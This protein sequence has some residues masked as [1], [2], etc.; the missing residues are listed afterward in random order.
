MD[1]KRQIA[2]LLT[3]YMTE[4]EA[5][6]ALTPPKDVAMGDICLPC[7][8]LAKTMRKSPILIAEEL[9][10]AIER[11]AFV[12]EITAVAGYL[13]FR[14]APSA[15]AHDI[16]DAVLTAGAAYGRTD[17]GGGRNVC[18]D[19]S[20][21][22]IAKPF[23][24]GHLSTTVLGAALARL[25]DEIGYHSVGINHLGDWGT[26][27]GKLIVAY[28]RWSSREDIERGGVRRLVEIYVK[29]HQEAETDPSLDDEARA[30]FKRLEDG[31][32][33]AVTLW[34]WFKQI[35]LA[36]D[37]PVYE[38][39]GV[40]F[41]SM[42]GE[43][44]YND[45]MQAVID[46]LQAKGLLVDSQGAKIVE[47]EG[48]APCIIVK[49]DG[50][51][52]YATRDL[53][54]AKYRHDTYDFAKC[55]YVV[56]YQQNL[57]F[58]QVFSVLRKMGYDWATDMQHV[59][60]GMVSLEEGAMST[61]KGNAVWLVDV[62]DKAVEKAK[63]IIAEKSP[64]L[65]E[66]DKVAEMVGVGSV[67]F[68]ALSNNRIKDIE[69]RYDRILNFDGETCPYVQYTHARCLSVLSKATGADLSVADYGCLTDDVS[70]EIVR[71]LDR[72]P[73]LLLD[74]ADKCEPSMITRH[75]VD[76][77]KLYN[78][79]YFD[80][81]ILSSPAGVREARIALTRAVAT[82][83][84]NGMSIAGIRLPDKM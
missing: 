17:F 29:F 75:V 67:I 35:T 8:R 10:A 33:E 43:S 84:E 16:I 66:A 30:W 79:F 38:R 69:F 21:I 52:L 9:A 59:A 83:I 82:V 36:D 3:P 53:A 26:Q 78:K 50:A 15:F 5:L 2:Q 81:K 60:F 23:H 13:N 39:L 56:A 80:N 37:M 46:E 73:S 72:Y 55:L 14:Y 40:H 63:T 41:D 4:E 20:S 22:N 54:A 19:F 68:S 12:S 61:R 70:K 45:K 71:Y 6:Q 49:S 58:K 11:P 1:Y 57:H 18:I 48:M 44:F 28:H 31:D 25:Y 34:Q 47:L 74:A 62:M 32:A 76:L 42:A 65:A 27:F 64:D 24:I 77:C 7:F 51:T